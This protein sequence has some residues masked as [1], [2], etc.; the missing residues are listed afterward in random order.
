MD[1][2]TFDTCTALLTV[3]SSLSAVAL[4]G[5]ESEIVDYDDES[6]LTPLQELCIHALAT[7]FVDLDVNQEALQAQPARFVWTL[8]KKYQEYNRGHPYYRNRW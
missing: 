2:L 4:L 7:V 3:V 8:V 1:S 5:K 6:A